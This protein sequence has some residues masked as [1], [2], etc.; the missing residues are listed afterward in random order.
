MVEVEDYYVIFGPDGFLGI[1]YQSS[2]D[3]VWEEVTKL[4]ME[5]FAN[6]TVI[7]AIN[8]T[9]IV[10]VPKIEVAT[11]MNH[12]RPISLC[13]F[14]YKLISKII[15]N[16]MKSLMP[17]CI[18]LN[19]RAFVSG[20]LIQDNIIV[21]HEAFHHLKTKK[22]W[23]RYEMALKVDMNK[24]YDRVEWSFVRKVLLKMGFCDGWVERIMMCLSS[25]KYSLLLSG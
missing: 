24:A 7:G 11:T 19:Q 3:I 15:V 13:N 22:S 14:S 10:L 4:V 12:F 9:N 8:D 1:F 25:I 20:R 5:F 17:R 6:G 18:S 23:K 2:W 21:A 16:R